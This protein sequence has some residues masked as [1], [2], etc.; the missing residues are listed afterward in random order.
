MTLWRQ[1][2]CRCWLAFVLRLMMRCC[3]LQLGNVNELLG[4]LLTERANSAPAGLQQRAR[5]QVG[6]SHRPA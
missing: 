3:P 6:S 5:K 4:T 1:C 2:T